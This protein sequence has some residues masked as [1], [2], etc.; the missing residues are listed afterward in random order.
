MI[1]LTEVES[2]ILACIETGVAGYLSQDASLKE[3]YRTMHAVAKGEP[4][5]SPKIVG[6]LF[7][8]VAAETQ[9]R[10]RILL[11]DW[12]NLTRR[13]L[14]ILPLIEEG[15]SNK[16]IALRLHIEVRTVKNHIH[17][18]LRKLQLEGRR[19][20]ARFAREHGLFARP[21]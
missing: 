13:E 18:I 4:F 21:I 7:T 20:A 12:V 10:E 6:A 3:L 15:L 11:M 9:K 1:G 17:N 19:E 16:E 14:E 5:C 2:D 8:R